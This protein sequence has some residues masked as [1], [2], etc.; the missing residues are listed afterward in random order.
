MAPNPHGRVRRWM[1]LCQ[2]HCKGPTAHCLCGTM[3]G[4]LSQDLSL[5]CPRTWSSRCYAKPPSAPPSWT[6]RI[7]GCSSSSLS[8]PL[9]RYGCLRSCASLPATLT[10][11]SPWKSIHES[12]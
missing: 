12:G 10:I 5:P 4:E 2:G 11:T 6:S 9:M 8:H 1:S 3:R 7:P